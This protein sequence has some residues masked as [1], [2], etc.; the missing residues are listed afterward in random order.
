[1]VLAVG[2]KALAKKKVN[3]ELTAILVLAMLL[4]AFSVANAEVRKETA[5]NTHK[6]V[7]NNKEY[8]VTT[9]V[10]AMIDF[11]VQSITANPSTIDLAPGEAKSFTVSA[12]GKNGGVIGAIE[13][14]NETSYATSDPAIITVKKENNLANVYAAANAQNGDSEK[15]NITYRADG[16]DFKA[17]ITVKIVDNRAKGTLIGKIVDADDTASLVGGVVKIFDGNNLLVSEVTTQEDGSYETRLCQEPTGLQYFPS[18]LC[19]GYIICND[20]FSQYNYL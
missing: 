12:I 7:I 3:K 19:Y 1:M 13:V 14:A 8:V 16:K 9:N 18:E 10:E 2:I 17:E 15:I 20:K 4:P 6:L 5:A 11:S